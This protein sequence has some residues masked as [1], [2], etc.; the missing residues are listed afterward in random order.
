MFVGVL[1]LMVLFAVRGWAQEPSEASRISPP[2]YPA[3]APFMLEQRPLPGSLGG[4]GGVGM[5]KARVGPGSAAVPDS[6]VAEYLDAGRYDELAR[7]FRDRLEF[8]DVTAPGRDP[9]IATVVKNLGLVYQLQ[10]RFEEAAALYERALEL[11]RRVDG[12]KSASTAL[13]ASQLATVYQ[14]LGRL[15]DAER[16][17]LE[18]VG[19]FEQIRDPKHLDTGLSINNLA[20]FYLSQ[21]KVSEARELFQRALRIFEGVR[22]PIHSDVG[23]A[24]TNLALCAKFAGDDKEARGHFMRAIEIFAALGPDRPELAIAQDNIAGFLAERGLWGEALAA[25][26]SASK[27][28]VRQAARGIHQTTAFGGTNATRVPWNEA[29]LARY[30]RSAWEVWRTYDG[31]DAVLPEKAFR[32]AQWISQTSTA[33]AL[34]DMAA[35]QATG[36]DKL[37]ALARRRQDLLAEWQRLDRQLLDALMQN[38]AERDR[39]REQ[40]LRARLDV[41]GEDLEVA[42]R[43]LAQDFPDYAALVSPRPLGI[44]KVQSLLADDEALILFQDTDA[45]LGRDGMTFVWLITRTESRWSAVRR[46]AAH[47][48]K[49]KAD[50]FLRDHVDA[51]RCGLDNVSAWKGTRC[52]DLLGVVYTEED[53]LGGTPPPFR[54]KIAH[55][56][57]D[58][59]FGD[60][61]DVIKNKRHLIIVPTGPLTQLPFQVLV[62]ER[63]ASDSVHRQA[64]AEA[65]WLAKRHALTVLPSVNALASLRRETNASR[66]EKPFIGFANPLLDGNPRS[67]IDRTA[68]DFARSIVGCAR[69]GEMRT[70]RRRA[71]HEPVVPLGGGNKPLPGSLVGAQSPLPE[72][73]DEVCSVARSLGGPDAVNLGN[74]AT[75][76]R[77]KSLSAS[78]ELATYRIIHFATHGALAGELDGI[79]E[80][81]LILTPP[82]RPTAE[83]DGYL[84]ASEIAGLKL[85][86][87]WVILSACNTAAGE[88]SEAEALSGLTKAFFYA[89][90]RSLLVSHW[91]VDSVA[92]VALITEAARALNRN[93]KMGRSEALRLAMLALMRSQAGL[94][95]PTYWAPFVVVG[96]GAARQ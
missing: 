80:P 27:I 6:V 52:F 66:A 70:A 16:L 63:P 26:D 82:K 89:G 53:R 64:F 17:H 7:L 18:A 3:A 59:L 23:L 39:S 24:H 65:A 31:F 71:L 8:L 79:R 88:T 83:D 37:A 29:A 87:D 75:E 55:R 46:P 96:E 76:S 90:A 72:T 58:A 19:I 32:R 14:A 34:A 86:A 38:A 78:G 13:A 84:S 22:G 41:V 51:L 44:A 21:R 50:S 11:R 93:P 43:G 69:S 49:A 2:D 81:G 10:A 12:D 56:L 42:D 28:V 40:E 9:R 36:D 54:L 4:G 15:E 45:A 20:H 94:W 35:R 30:L 60:I 57:Y 74:Q 61:E 68:A 77:L 1:A 67:E 91:Y 95:H 92:T 33:K 47:E 5:G 62:T 73:A 48:G 25:A 85:N